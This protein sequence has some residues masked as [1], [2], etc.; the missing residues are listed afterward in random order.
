VDVV[1][2]LGLFL[3]A[4][5]AQ[6]KAAGHRELERLLHKPALCWHTHLKALLDGIRA[7]QSGPVLEERFRLLH[8]AGEAL[9]RVGAVK[10]ESVASMSAPLADTGADPAKADKAEES[11]PQVAAQCLLFSMRQFVDTLRLYYHRAST[12]ALLSFDVTAAQVSVCK[13]A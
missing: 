3:S 11:G 5:Q 10:K 8:N 6:L 2:Q 1:S 12:E 13:A 7:G 4:A 9:L